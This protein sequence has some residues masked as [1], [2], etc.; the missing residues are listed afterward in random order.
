[1][2]T[3]EEYHPPT[4]QLNALRA[5][6]GFS[7]SDIAEYLCMN[8]SSYSRRERGELLFNIREINALLDLFRVPFDKIFRV[9]KK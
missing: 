2:Y 9:R 7:Q 6:R 1:M 5:V 8:A 3:K 4:R